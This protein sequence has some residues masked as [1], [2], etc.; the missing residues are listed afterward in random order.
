[1]AGILDQYQIDTKNTHP[2]IYGAN[3]RSQTFQAG[4]TGLLSTIILS[5]FKFGSAPNLIV[6]IQGVNG[7]DKPDGNVLAS[8]EI[9]A[10]SIPISTEEV[11]IDFTA[12]TEVVSGSNYSI[13][14]HAKADGGDAS[15]LL[16]SSGKYGSPP[17]TNGEYV[18]S[19][20]SGSTWTIDSLIDLY[21][22]TYVLQNT[23]WENIDCDI[24]VLQE[25]TSDINSDIR[26]VS[27]HT[28]IRDINSIIYTADRELYDLNCDIRVSADYLKLYDINSDIRTRLETTYDINCDIR[29]VS[30]GAIPNVLPDIDCD[31]RV[32]SRTI[33]DINCDIR[34]V[35]DGRETDDINCD[36]RVRGIGDVEPTPV[37]LTG[38]RVYLNGN[39]ISDVQLDSIK[40]EWTM[41]ETP[42]SATFRIARKSDD[43]NETLA[44]VAQAI[45]TNLPIEIKFNGNLRWYGYVMSIDV[46]HSGESAIVKC[47]DR[48]HKI[49]EKLYDISYGRKWE[50]PEPGS[51]QVTTGTYAR[52]GEAITR[53]LNLLVSAGIISSY[54]GVPTGIIPEYN[55]TQGTPAGILITELLDESGNFYWNVTPNG[56]LEIYE[57][58]AGAIKYLPLQ[59]END[60]I[61]L[62][63]VVNYNFTLNDRS[64]LITTV[65][66]NMGTESEEMRASYKRKSLSNPL[67]PAWDRSLDNIYHRYYG[68]SQQLEQ[69]R[70]TDVLP[71]FWGGTPDDQEKKKE[72]GRR[73]Q[74]SSWTEGSFIDDKF[75]PTVIGF[76]NNK[77]S[78]WSWEGKYLTLA[79]PL[80]RVKMRVPFTWSG[81]LGTVYSGFYTTYSFQAPILIGGYYQKEDILIA[82]TPTIF[83]VTWI[84]NGGVGA[85]RKATFSQ[86]GIREAIGW[87]VYEDGELVAKSEPGYN[88]TAYA[89]DKAR[90]MLSRIN[91][92]VTEGS[93][94]LTFDAFEYYGLKLGKRINLTQTNETN[95]YNGN[96]GFPVDVESI[97]F[98]ANNYQVTLN[99]KHY[100]NFKTTVNFR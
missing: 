46:E 6:E 40:Y 51:H 88:D 35:E 87:S 85:T 77:I 43:F 95:I 89:T 97:Q 82:T 8:Q 10:A 45:S 84:G 75:K 100:R 26:T 61:N 76:G 57:A 25:V 28:V 59:T 18:Y 22:K 83:S 33:S 93:I 81:E 72:V 53:I 49:Q 24:R 50:A 55:E 69:L 80:L 9:P 36:I 27:T 31:I 14:L 30:A 44:G 19:L 13:V 4:I 94:N 91:D 47:L 39:D 68:T 99:I 52:T 17:Y 56:K 41:N 98:N 5:L 64:N 66:V 96:N 79:V 92:L 74:I 86:L 38:F 29:V 23:I 16:Y 20:N 37:G 21:F 1:M 58:S 63:D 15:N 3:Y 7:N 90:L 60:R 62:Y 71:S 2:T 34:V 70:D 42:A 73:W 65:E 54:S 32:L 12:P 67:T 48:K 11:I 78:G